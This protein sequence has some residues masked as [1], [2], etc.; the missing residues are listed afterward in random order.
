MSLCL[1]GFLTSPTF[2]STS[3]ALQGGIVTV[4]LILT[5]PLVLDLY[6]T[7]GLSQ[8]P[9][10]NTR[11]WYE[12]GYG[13]AKARYHT[14]APIL[15]KEGLEKHRGPFYIFSDSQYRL[16]L[17][18]RYAHMIRNEDRL[19]L[20]VFFNEEFHAHIAGFEPFKELNA[21]NGIVR[22]VINYKLSRSLPLLVDPISQEA[23]IALRRYWGDDPEWREHPLKHSVDSTI[24]QVM[25][26]AFLMDDLCQDRRWLDIVVEYTEQIFLVA[27]V[28]R[29]WPKA[30]RALAASF[31]PE[32]RKLRMLLQKARDLLDPVIAKK[33]PSCDMASVPEKP[34]PSNLGT[35]K[36]FHECAKGRPYDA[37]AMQLSF[38][39]VAIDTTSDTMGNLLSDIAE[40]PELQ[41]AMREEIRSVFENEGLSKPAL[42]KL[43]LMDSVMKESQRLRPGGL[44]AM[45]RIAKDKVVLPDGTN[46]PR[47]TSIMV[48]AH[49]TLDASIEP[50][51]TRF[52]G[53]RFVQRNE[54][55]TRNLSSQFVSTSPNYLGFGHG[56]QACPGR[57]FAAMEIKITLCHML[58]NYD[59]KLVKDRNEQTLVKGHNYTTCPRATIVI[60]RRKEVLQL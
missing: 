35:F 60:R 6:Y 46:I 13:P 24:A 17:P 39:F 54:N 23:T 26:R 41:E 56:K 36:W 8:L 42:Q 1:S 5:Y 32:S 28:L 20:A 55:A 29:R 3:L 44:V 22:D 4:L 14:T 12:L 48:A 27:R 49:Q 50:Q 53:Y 19:S 2:L 15:I 9:R 45:Q 16:V 7:F 59:M 11:R 10:Y 30:L 37:A 34:S 58:L 57:F 47:G 40:R 18:T 51:D 31:L 21:D 52:D 43:M 38:A 25:S 33:I